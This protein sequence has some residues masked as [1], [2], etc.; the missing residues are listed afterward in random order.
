[1]NNLEDKIKYKNIVILADAGI[2]D[3]IWATSALSL[4]RQYDKNIEITLVTCDKYVDLID[5]SLKINK[6]I[7]TNNKYHVNKNKFIRLIYK[8][9]WSIKNFKNFYKKDTCLILDISMFFTVTAKYL[10]RI[11]NII[12]PDNFSF[13]HNVYNKSSKFYTKIVKMPKDSDRLSYMMRYQIITRTI[14]PIF[15]LCLPVIPDTKFL[16]DKVLNLIGRTKKIRI[17]I[18]PCGSVPWRK[19]DISFLQNL[20][21]K[22]N[23]LYD[24]TF[25]LVGNSKEEKEYSSEILNLLKNENIDIR[26]FVGKTSLLELKEL[27]NNTNLLLT[28]DTGTYHIAA[29]TN[30]PIIAVHGGTLPENSGAISSKV[31]SLCSYRECAPCTLK[32]VKDSFVCRNP[33]CIKDITHEMVIERVKDILNERI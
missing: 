23:K 18:S 30:I 20:I 7:T 32:V 28:V 33:L 16:Q 22:L 27:F 24:I 17:V 4:I 26:N 21:L 1:M 11:K 15:N 2:G 31:I 3:F 12:G 10:Y 14:F 19:F 13:G 5:K 6:I 29:T 8:L 25:F 9:F